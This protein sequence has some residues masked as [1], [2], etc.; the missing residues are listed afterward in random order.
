MDRDALQRALL[1]DRLASY[2]RLGGGW[3]IPLAGTVYWGAL[4]FF[5][6]Q[7]VSLQTWSMA[8][9]LGTGA[10][11]PLA[12][13]FAKL[14]GNPFLKDRAAVTSVLVPTFISMLLFWPMVVAAVQE[15]PELIPLI[16]AIGL[17]LHWPVIGWSYGR[18]ALFAAHAVI[19]AV[20]VLMI[21]L[22]LPEARLTALPLAVA[23]IYLLTVLAI[24]VDTTLLGRSQAMS[25]E[26]DP[27]A[28][29]DALTPSTCGASRP[30]SLD[31][32]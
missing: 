31:R 6:A 27:S 11:F 14:A 17:S 10:I 3:P 30:I 28:P 9:F 21:W 32:I 5:G 22:T 29:P 25:G 15:G 16:L 1:A 7:G 23:S 18:T 19:R 13:L 2:L 12:L 26:A 8:A 20:L 4:A 24:L